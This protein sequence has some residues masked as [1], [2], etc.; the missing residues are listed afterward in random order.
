LQFAVCLAFFKNEP[1]YQTKRKKEMKV[2]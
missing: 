1:Q 2:K